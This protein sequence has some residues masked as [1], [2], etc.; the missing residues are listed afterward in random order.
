MSWVLEQLRKTP[1]GQK[2]VLNCHVRQAIEWMVQA[3]KM[4]HV[5][6]GR[7]CWV[8]SK[9]LSLVQ[10]EELRTGVRHNNRAAQDERG[11]TLPDQ[12]IDDLSDLLSQ[13]GRALSTDP[14]RPIKMAEP[15]DLCDMPEERVVIELPSDGNNDDG[16]ADEMP[17][18]NHMEVDDDDD[19][20]PT[21]VETNEDIDVDEYAPDLPVFTLAEARYAVDRLYEFAAVNADYIQKRH[22]NVDHLQNIALLR[23]AVQS[24]VI[25]SN[26]RQAHITNFFRPTTYAI[27]DITREAELDL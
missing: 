1:P 7:N 6:V 23:L 25:T 17:A 12:V 16:S 3:Q 20:S 14:S 9:I 11:S 5:S 15:A 26:A 22:S 13:L 24:M 27:N 2:P 18:A 21:Q 10:L 19:D 4:M 8:K